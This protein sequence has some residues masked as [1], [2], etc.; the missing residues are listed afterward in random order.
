MQTGLQ[1]FCSSVLFNS[2]LGGR[3]FGC[4]FLAMQAS[5]HEIHEFYIQDTNVSHWVY[6]HM[7]HH[8]VS[9]Y[10]Y[11]TLFPKW[12][13]SQLYQRQN[14]TCHQGHTYSPQTNTWLTQACYV[15][16]Y[17]KHVLVTRQEVLVQRAQYN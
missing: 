14:T 13:S 3:G 8:S 4:N 7:T 15:V 12:L 11:P 17:V 5:D 1:L 10:A 6:Q 2:T 16:W 9:Y